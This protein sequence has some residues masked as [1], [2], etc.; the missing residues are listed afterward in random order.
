MCMIC[1]NVVCPSSCPSA[2]DADPSEE[3][4]LEDDGAP[5]GECSACGR[6][7]CFG[8]TALILEDTVL[9]EACV[10]EATVTLTPERDRCR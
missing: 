8:D 10:A 5:V 4:L 9:C 6:A 3:L 2:V 1:R 7:L